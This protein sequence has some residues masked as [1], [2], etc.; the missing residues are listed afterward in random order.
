[1]VSF[2]LTAAARVIGPAE[3][4]FDA[5]FMSFCFEQFLDEL[6]P[7]IDIDLS[8]YPTGTKCPL[9]GIDSLS[10]IFVQVHLA[11]HTIAGTIIGESGDINLSDAPERFMSPDSPM[12]VP[13]IV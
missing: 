12:I 6:F 8:G 9:Q 10:S 2:D 3:D 4:Q 11:S 7:I 5:V 1:M 13:A